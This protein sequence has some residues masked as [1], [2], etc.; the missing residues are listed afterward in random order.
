ME[1]QYT[2][3]Q[4]TEQIKQ[5]IDN[6][7]RVTIA[8]STQFYNSL[9]TALDKQLINNKIKIISSPIIKKNDVYAMV[10]INYL[11]FTKVSPSLRIYG[12]HKRG[13]TTT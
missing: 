7:E 8:V 12:A 11:D 4:F 2:I 3:Q 6:G 5:W 10:D 13:W 1:K 9:Q